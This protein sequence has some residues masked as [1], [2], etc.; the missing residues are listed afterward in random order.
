[1]YSFREIVGMANVVPYDCIAIWM[2][3][4]RGTVP[5]LPADPNISR[6]ACPAPTAN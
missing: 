3:A 2:H 1:V 6:A 4:T 5:I